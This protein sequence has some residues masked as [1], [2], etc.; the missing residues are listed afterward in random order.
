MTDGEV[1]PKGTVLERCPGGV[2]MGHWAGLVDDNGYP[3]EDAWDEREQAEYG[4]VSMK[5][6]CSRDSPCECPVVCEVCGENT[7]DAGTVEREVDGEMRA[8]VACEACAEEVE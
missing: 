4:G 8:F 6:R 7:W 5:C 3:L 2:L 1:P